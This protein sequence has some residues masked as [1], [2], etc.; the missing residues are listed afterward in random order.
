[1]KRKHK[2]N[3]LYINGMRCNAKRT[4]ICDSKGDGVEE[5]VVR[6]TVRLNR[7]RIGWGE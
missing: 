5:R 7:Y 6:H 2:R 1:M 4:D 3:P